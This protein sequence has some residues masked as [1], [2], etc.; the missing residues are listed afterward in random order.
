MR[1]KLKICGLRSPDN[2]RDVA[3]LYPDFIGFIFYERSKRYVGASFEMPAALPPTV[4]RVGVFVDA[5]PAF[6]TA[7]VSRYGLDFVQLHGGESVETCAIRK[8]TGV[9]VIKVFGIG[10]AMDFAALAPFEHVVDFFLFDT[11]TDGYGGSGK[12]FDWKLLDSYPL[13]T[14]FFL[15][16]GLT[17]D[18]LAAIGNWHH[19]K[20]FA[21]DFNSGVEDAPGLKSIDKIKSVQAGLVQL[22]EIK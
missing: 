6:M 7:T 20:L 10:A 8:E 21:L 13:T 9:G 1:P 14:P 17:I 16:G 4:K 19:P 3:A 12:T 22:N 11:K 2:I 18:H 5:D 15:S